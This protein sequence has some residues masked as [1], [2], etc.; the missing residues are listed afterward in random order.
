MS[1]TIIFTLGIV[2]AG[3]LTAAGIFAVALRRRP[4]RT[5]TARTAGRETAPSPSDSPFAPSTTAAERFA[6]V[7]ADLPGETPAAV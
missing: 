6:A 7:E 2:G 4:A 1:V 3:I 5:V